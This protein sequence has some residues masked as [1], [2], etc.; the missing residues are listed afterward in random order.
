[1]RQGF[2][3]I[4]PVLIL[5]LLS[6]GVG[7]QTYSIRVNVNA[8]IRAQPSLGA[9]WLETVPAGTILEVLS[10]SGRWFKIN[11]KGG[12]WMA[13]WL[14]HDRVAAPAAQPVLDNCCGIDRECHSEAEWIA[15]WNAYQAGQCQR[16]AKSVQSS[17]Q[18]PAAAGQVIDNC[19]GLDRECHSE[20]EWIAGW[21]AY[22]AGQCQ[23]PAK[24]VQPVVHQPAAAPLA[25]IDNCCHLD[26]SCHSEAEWRAGYA[27]FQAL[28]CW[29][30][31]VQWKR[32][33]DP[34]YM[35]ASGSDNCCTAPGWLCLEDEHFRQGMW[36]F[37]EYKHCAPN[38][39][40]TYLPRL[41]AYVKT[42]NCC[43]YGWNCPTDQNWVD[44]YH[45]YRANQCPPPQPPASVAGGI[46]IH[47]PAD[48]VSDVLRA[49]HWLLNRAPR[50]HKY[51]TDV[52][53]SIRLRK[54]IPGAWVAATVDPRSGA[55][56]TQS[57]SSPSQDGLKPGQWREPVYGHHRYTLIAM[58][59]VHEA[60][61]VHAHRN[62]TVDRCHA[63]FAHFGMPEALRDIDVN[64]YY[65]DPDFGWCPH[66]T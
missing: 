40:T 3:I 13:G 35:P 37:Q 45:A 18:Q 57:F 62:G 38:V 8:N 34:R 28:E 60:C 39:K 22:Q 14:S 27:A 50:W 51:V 64:R 19:C 44:G 15:G 61:H 55:V 52:V 49:F 12:A 63:G 36:A 43:Y 30:A 20:A 32:T 66:I 6:F 65:D 29:D 10:Q 23:R 21:N 31:Y 24:S 17:A 11:R 5:T 33:P 46:P 47:G 25:R 56:S 1:M 26:R 41:D 48:Y 42:E 7:A 54:Q 4:I 59:L 2:K 16:P 58:L 53:S 9:T